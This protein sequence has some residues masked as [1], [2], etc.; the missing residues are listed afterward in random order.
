MVV[1]QTD[2]AA[3]PI[4]PNDNGSANQMYLNLLTAI[5]NAFGLYNVYPIVIAAVGIIA[6]VGLFGLMR[7]NV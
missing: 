2:T 5:W 4:I 1:Q 6:I 3:A 7:R